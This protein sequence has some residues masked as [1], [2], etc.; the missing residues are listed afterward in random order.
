MISKVTGV[1]K[2]E[3]E[4]AFSVYDILFP[5]VG[6]ASWMRVIGGTHI[7]R[8]NFMPAPIMGIGANFRRDFY[9]KDKAE[10]DPPYE[11]LKGVLSSDY[12]Y[13]N[14]LL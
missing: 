13:R 4:T 12:T 1:P 6:S 3:V 7:R 8:L 2:D 10:K 14:L 9:R 5:L 11:D